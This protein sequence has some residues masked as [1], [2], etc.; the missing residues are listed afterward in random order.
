MSTTGGSTPKAAPGGDSGTTGALTC[1]GNRVLDVPLADRPGASIS[2]LPLMKRAPGPVPLFSH[3]PN[4]NSP[5]RCRLQRGPFSRNT[6]AGRLTLFG[7]G[8]YHYRVACQIVIDTACDP[9]CQRADE[10][11]TPDVRQRATDM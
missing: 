1:P 3:V 5:R 8:R 11:Q 7:V 10:Q 9:A 6:N 2:L 4:T